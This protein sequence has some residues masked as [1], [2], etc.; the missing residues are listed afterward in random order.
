MSGLEFGDAVGIDVE[1]DDRRT[2]PGEGDGH[3]QTDIA[4]PDNGELSNV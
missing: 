4:E 1:A 2:L 3:R